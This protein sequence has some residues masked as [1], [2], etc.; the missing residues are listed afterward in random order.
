MPQK[1]KPSTVVKDFKTSKTKVQ[2]FYMHTTSTEELLEAFNKDSTAPKV[3]Q[4]IKNELV[5]RKAI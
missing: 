3:K 4:K 1:F 2:H 5:K